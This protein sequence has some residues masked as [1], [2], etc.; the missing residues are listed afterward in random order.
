M[1]DERF[2]PD[3]DAWDP[4]SPD[5]VAR[6]LSGS[7][8]P[9]CVA[10]GWAIDLCLGQVTREHEDLE[11]ALP[12]GRADEILPRFPECDFF[13]VDS[14]EAWL[15]S[16]ETGDSSHQTWVR[17][18]ST[19]SWRFDLVREPHDGDIWICR[20]NPAIRMPY[21]ILIRRTPDGIPFVVPEVTL[22]FKAKATREKDEADFTNVLPHLER[23]ALE[24]LHDALHVTHPDHPWIERL[25]DA[26][27]ARR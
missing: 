9:W 25:R 14:G 6:R 13:A 19:G 11:I 7:T 27:E 16:P 5:E 3:L 2:V 1:S 10:G 22:L 17:E 15:W 8:A 21:K 20:R 12:R 24:W 26:L 18:R 4:W 23:H